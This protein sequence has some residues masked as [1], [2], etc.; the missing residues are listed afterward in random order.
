YVGGPSAL[1]TPQHGTATLSG[2]QVV[3]APNAG[4]TG[5]D[6]FTYTITDGQG[7]TSTATVGVTVGSSSSNA[8]LAVDDT[9][10]T[11]PDTSVTINVLANDTGY[12]GGPNRVGEPGHGATAGVPNQG[13]YKPDTGYAAPHFV[14]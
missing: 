14:A 3:Y 1:S 7:H 9:A 12:V 11:A 5:A 8:L 10:V 6:S 2:A 13:G 4:Y